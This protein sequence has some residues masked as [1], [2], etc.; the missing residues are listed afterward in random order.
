[1]NQGSSILSGAFY[2]QKV[3]L[4]FVKE[5]VKFW[6]RLISKEKSRRKKL[7]CLKGDTASV[8]N[9]LE[10]LK[11]HRNSF[12]TEIQTENFFCGE[13]L[14]GKFWFKLLV[15]LTST[16]GAVTSHCKKEISYDC[17]LKVLFMLTS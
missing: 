2:Y 15:R 4:K 7:I 3:Q 1:M 9:I 13:C 10:T 11:G 8:K 6:I 5:V 14:F 17:W 12:E 16:T